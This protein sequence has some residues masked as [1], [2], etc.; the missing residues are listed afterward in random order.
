MKIAVGM[1]GGVDSSTVTKLLL[2]EGHNVIGVTM[3]LFKDDYT[4][5]NACYSPD[6][7]SNIEA[8]RKQC[9]EL[10]IPYHVVDV[11]DEFASYVLDYIK[12]SYLNGRTPN[13]CVQC[14]STVKFGFFITKIHQLGLNVDKFATGH[15]AQIVEHDGVYYLKSNET[16]KDQVYFLY[17]V[18]QDILSK[19]LFPL[20]GMTKDETR[21]LAHSF[22]L[23]VAD[24]KDSQDFGDMSELMDSK[25]GNIVYNGKVIGKHNGITNYTVGQRRGLNTRLNIPLFVRQI[26]PLTSEVIVTDSDGLFDNDCEI[27][28]AFILPHDWIQGEITAKIRSVHTPVVIRDIT[29]TKRGYAIEFVQPQ[30]GI[31]PGQSLVF[32]K[33][34]FVIGGGIISI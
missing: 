16:S 20:G 32:Y 10:G 21:V 26:N 24:K 19:T 18:S 31:T 12:D 13:P 8:C 9:Q 34:G 1:S 23:A 6:N 27:T 14:N 25:P 4:Y 15:Y 2:Q 17:R 29:E 28:D 22:G 33:D 30:R 7:A 3:K 11:S 5:T